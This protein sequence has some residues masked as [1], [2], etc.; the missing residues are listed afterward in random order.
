MSRRSTINA[1]LGVVLL[2]L[3]GWLV[4]FAVQGGSAAPGSTPAEERAQQY[5]DIR[6]TARDAT[7]AFLTIDHTRMDA[8]T[9]RVLDVATG[10]FE[11]QYKS[12][13]ESL[14]ESAETQ[15]SFADGSVAEVGL[16]E[17]DADSATA[18][19]AAGSTVRNKS[20]DG[21]EEERSWRIKLTMVK[22]G[23]RWLV[24]QLE[25]VG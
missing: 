17:V 23:D 9:Q 24:S 1:V 5:S 7:A 10:D 20:T 6:R 25:F 16:S 14:K 18:F 2:G 19:V 13:L 12:S 8:V 15:E 22:E 21:K 11:K 4:L 3:L